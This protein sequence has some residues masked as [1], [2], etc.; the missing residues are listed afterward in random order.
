MPSS[1]SDDTYA[2]E[3]PPG[4]KIAPEI[5]ALIRHYYKQ[6]DNQGNH[7]EY[8]ECWAEDGILIVPDGREFRGR[9]GKIIAFH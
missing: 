5:Q 1:N 7:V 4:C 3:Y 8:S 2:S 9:E 6:V